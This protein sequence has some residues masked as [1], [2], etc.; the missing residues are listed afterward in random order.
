MNNREFKAKVEADFLEGQQSGVRGTPAFFING[1]MISGA[2]PFLTFKVE[3]D[4]AL[5]AAS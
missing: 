3:I 5:A 1:K 2:Q 4:A